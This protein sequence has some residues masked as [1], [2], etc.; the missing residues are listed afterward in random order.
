MDID[1]F[2]A[3]LLNAQTPPLPALLPDASATHLVERLKA[4][5][6]RHWRIDAHVSLRCAD[7]I[8]QIGQTREQAPT[9]ALGLMARGDALK[10][11][12]RMQDAWDT[13]EQAG[14]LY[15]SAGDEVGWARTRI[16]RLGICVNLNRV[17]TAM[18]EAEQAREIF[19]RF[20]DHEKLLRL[21][22][23]AAAAYDQLGNFQQSQALYHQ[24]LEIAET[25]GDAGQTRLGMIYNNL[26]YTQQEMGNLREALFYYEQATAIWKARNEGSGV[27]VAE[28]NI[29]AV[30]Q[31]QGK[32]RKALQL[33]YG[34]QESLNAFLPSEVGYAQRCMI[35]CYLSLNRYADARTL[36]ETLIQQQTAPGE[37]YNLALILLH[38]ATAEAQ[39]GGYAQAKGAL[40]KA[41]AIFTELKSD[42]WLAAIHLRRGRIALQ[43]GD[44]AAALAESTTAASFFEHN[45][46][47]VDYTNALLLQGQIALAKG[48]LTAASGAG[49]Q[50]LLFARRSNVSALRYRAHLVLGEIAERQD[51]IHAA[52]RHYRQA[53]AVLERVQHNLTITLRSD[54]FEDKQDALRALIRLYLRQAQ[55]KQ[56]FQALERAKSQLWMSYL[57]NREQ[58]RWA[59]DDP[60]TRPLIEELNRL[61]EEHHW[62]YRI[63][64][65][66]SFR[67]IQRVN[68]QPQQAASEV[69]SRE[70]RMQTL[71]ERLYLHSSRDDTAQIAAV[72]LP[73]IQA[74]LTESD[75]LVEFY[76]DGQQTWVF[77]IDR[78]SLRVSLLP[79]D[80]AAVG[81]L[82]EQLQANIARALR[83]GPQAQP[84][85]ALTRLAGQILRQLYTA[86]LAPIADQL[87]QYARVLFVPF[88]AL[89]Y[90]PFHL[91]HDGS[92]HLIE[93]HEV[94][95]LPA[96]GLV[97]RQPPKRQNGALVL[98][99][100]WQDRLPQ[101][102]D[103]AERVAQAF[104]GALY[105]NDQAQRSV[106][107]RIPRQVLHIAAHG[108]HRIDQPDMSYIELG[109]G[110]LLTDDLLQYD[111]SYELVTLS[112]CETGRASVTTSDE[113]IGLGRG[114]LYAGAGA[115]VASLWRV[116]DALTVQWMA[117]FYAGLRAGESKAAA[118]RNANRTLLSEHPALHPAFWGAFALI[119]NA[120]P[121]STSTDQTRG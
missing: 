1:A 53:A 85:Q 82:V 52:T 110:Q 94:V 103:E 39:L 31:A 120:D 81:K 89:H 21:R 28:L 47:Q 25:M 51:S 106:F 100:S 26:G 7:M 46:Q 50:A 113:L 56:A 99:H 91:L 121:L 37:N 2:V 71:T 90:L 6:D 115:L 49:K 20:G 119:G 73:E 66:Q 38:L 11:L 109:D 111:L 108:Q 9:I 76:S 92:Q 42:A 93:T 61:R 105:C 30:A 65:D 87:A 10:L 60:Y 12:N 48:D 57:S 72:G 16:G 117:H 114:F 95:I 17:E 19:L 118:L 88:G 96:S 14:A 32:Y 34:T 24:A 4:E 78:Q 69:R 54:Y 70:H 75:L 35:E 44:L 18:D 112:A 84:T 27:A 101:T 45:Q 59:H 33:L 98:A 97:T 15:L 62:F 86:L 68:I 80:A 8:V 74:S 40:D 22:L 55:P 83:S 63:A 36:A 116:D 77:T 41:A 107:A 3:Q 13:L 79:A 58:L 5:A 29:A 23:N 102:R 104:D 64:H 43:Q 67:E